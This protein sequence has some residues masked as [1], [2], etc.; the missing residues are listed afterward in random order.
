MNKYIAGFITGAALV[1]VGAL[2]DHA[3]LTKAM[4]IKKNNTRR[5]ARLILERNNLGHLIDQ[6]DQ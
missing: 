3:V 1:G 6:L 4:E 2:I 5:R